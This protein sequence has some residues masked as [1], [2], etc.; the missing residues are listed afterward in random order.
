MKLFGLFFT[1]LMLA[2]FSDTASA[3]PL[4]VSRRDAKFPTQQMVEKQ[5]FTDPLASNSS[6]IENDAAGAISA[7]AATLSS[8]F[9]AQPDVFRNL[10]I[11]PGGTTGD[12]ESCVITVSGTNAF[13]ASISDTFTFASD[14]TGKQV[15]VKAF[16]TVTSVSWPAN[17][18]SGGFA[19][20]WDIG[21]GEKLGMKRCMANKGDADSSLLNGDKEATGPTMV[22]DSDEVEKNTADFVGTMNGTNDFILYFYQNYGCFP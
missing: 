8:G 21:S 18:E 9:D 20:T 4:S 7:A 13:G 22:V 6:V 1:L 16:N 19:A 3:V 11:T 14:A 2:V 10:E 15:G 12:I 17:C 5:S